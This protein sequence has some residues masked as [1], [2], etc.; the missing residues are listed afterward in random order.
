ML[1]IRTVF[2]CTVVWKHAYV[3]VRSFEVLI[4]LKGHI[5]GSSMLKTRT[6]GVV[7]ESVVWGSVVWSCRSELCG[8]GGSRCRSWQRN[9]WTGA[10]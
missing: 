7:S 1:Y 6:H 8:S 2:P 3:E 9:E 5:S 10:C 4:D